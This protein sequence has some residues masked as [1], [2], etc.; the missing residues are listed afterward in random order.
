M[1][2]VIIDDEPQSHQVLTDLLGKYHPDIEYVGSAY[3]IKDAV[4]LIKKKQPELVFLDIELPD[5][6][7]FE[8]LKQIGKPDFY[9]IFI[10]GFGHYARS[11]IRFGALDYLLKPISRHELAEALKI[12]RAKR[13]EKISQDQIQILLE[14]FQNFQEKKLPTRIAISTSE[15]IIY[16]SVKNIIRLEAHQN[17]TKFSLAGSERRILASV[18]LGEYTEQFESYHEFMRVHRSHLIN[19]RYVDKYVRAGGGY[20]MMKDQ[21]SVSVSRLYKDELLKRLER[22]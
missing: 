12:T 8:L 7:S 18:N 1:L 13:K 14:T 20:V 11:A 3:S 9:I 22:L 16:R 15:G 5:G 19:L 17:Y 21:A 2:T 4:E 6:L 10:S